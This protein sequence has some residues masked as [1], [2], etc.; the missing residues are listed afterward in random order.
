MNR[1]LK[2]YGV[3]AMGAMA[4]GLF[5]T[6]LVGTILNTLGQQLGVGFLT[7]IGGFACSMVG[8]AMAVAIGY[9]LKAQPL[10]LFSLVPVGLATNQLG[11]AAPPI[12]GSPLLVASAA[13]SGPPFPPPISIFRIQS[14]FSPPPVF[15]I[16]HIGMKIGLPRIFSS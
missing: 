9:A 11:G 13:S 5:C 4:Q 6:L 8:P 16:Y 3:D 2:K 12:P 1:Y 10:V 14:P 15:L 7:R